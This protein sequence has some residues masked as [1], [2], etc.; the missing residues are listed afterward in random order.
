MDS[1]AA[2]YFCL[3]FFGSGFLSYLVPDLIRYFKKLR[4]RLRQKQRQAPAQ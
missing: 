3:G 1:S 4:L 2:F